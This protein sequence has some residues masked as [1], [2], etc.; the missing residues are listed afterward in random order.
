[1]D[2]S[3]KIWCINLKTIFEAGYSR[4]KIFDYPCINLYN[5][6]LY[7]DCD[8]LVTNSINNILDFQLENKLYALKEVIQMKRSGVVNFVMIIIIQIVTHLQLVYCYSIIIS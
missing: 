1:M 3:E 4:L 6:I 5:K 2:I 8:I 7:L